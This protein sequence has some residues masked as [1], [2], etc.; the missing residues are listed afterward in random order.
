MLNLFFKNTSD[1][2]VTIVYFISPMWKMYYQMETVEVPTRESFDAQVSLKG[3]FP[4]KTFYF[5]DFRFVEVFLISSESEQFSGEFSF[6][7]TEESL[8]ITQNE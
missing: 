6:I 4:D 5:S 3:T 2:T 1:C 8:K 7:L